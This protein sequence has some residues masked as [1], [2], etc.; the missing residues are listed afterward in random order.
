VHVDAQVLEKLT[1][2]LEKLDK[3]EPVC[4]AEMGVVS[5]AGAGAAGGGA[6]NPTIGQRR[7]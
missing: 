7:R 6:V 2:L 5:P 3:A 4:A 1:V